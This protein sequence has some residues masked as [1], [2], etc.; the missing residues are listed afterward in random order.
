MTIYA[1]IGRL[2]SPAA[3]WVLR[4]HNGLTK[5]VRPRVI[6]R[7]E[8]DEILLVQGWIGIQKW[9]LP[10]GDI[11]KGET[12]VDAA[13]RE[14]YEETGIVLAKDDLQ[15]VTT[16]YSHYE[17]PIYI[18]K[19]QRSSLPLTPHN[20]REI[21]GIGWFDVTELP[22]ARSVFIDHLSDRMFKTR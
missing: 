11:K 19:V 9:E 16:L 12:P 14:V 13:V 20:P 22:V 10:G 7:N 8:Q 18:A 21:I 1:T 3:L 17:A 15:Y 4:C 5:S 2:I 6:L